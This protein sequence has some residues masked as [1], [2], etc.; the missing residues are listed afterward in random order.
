MPTQSNR[1][2][3][4]SV[5]E[6]RANLRALFAAAQEGEVI[7]VVDAHRGKKLAMIV[8]HPDAKEDRSTAA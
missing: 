7:T 4:V 3:E 5:R 8:A 2:R 1:S 6:A